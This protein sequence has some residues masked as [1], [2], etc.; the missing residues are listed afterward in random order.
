MIDHISIGVRDVAAAK[1]FYDAALAPLGYSCLS[2]SAAS[3]CRTA[4]R[5]S[6]RDTYTRPRYPLATTWMAMSACDSP[7]ARARSP[8]WIAA[9]KSPAS[10]R[11]SWTTSAQPPGAVRPSRRRR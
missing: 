2:A 3:Q 9:P 8:A 4:S 7:M 1:R 10:P 11:V 5:H 6:P